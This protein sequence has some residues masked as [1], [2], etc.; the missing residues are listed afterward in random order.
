VDLD[1]IIREREITHLFHFTRLEN[2]SSI[3]E[4]GILSRNEL[5]ALQVNALVNDMNR[6]DR[7]TGA[8][9]LSI[10]FPSY[11]M[12]YQ[13]RAKSP[14][15]SWCVISVS[16]SLL[17]EV[18]CVFLTHN[19]ATKLMQSVDLETCRHGQGLSDL[20][21]DPVWPYELP[22][23]PDLKPQY[24][25]HPNHEVLVFPSIP[26]LHISGI[27]FNETW[28]MRTVAPRLATKWR[29]MCRVEKT[30]FGKR[31]DWRHIQSMNDQGRL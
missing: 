7:Q 13:C 12:F 3:L 15:S 9:S 2:L 5:D 8:V 25:T 6:Y 11:R 31:S 24:P 10:S 28:E 26:A 16:P 14:G 1:A 4:H 20:F 22:R 18:D 21:D 27:L 29:S 19:A 17:S 23:D 30:Y